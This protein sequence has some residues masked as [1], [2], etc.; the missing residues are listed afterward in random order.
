M[1]TP[2]P[3][4]SLP[5]DREIY[6][7]SLLQVKLTLAVTLAKKQIP[8][9]Q[10]IKLVPG[11]IIHFDK[12]C[13]KPLNLEV[14]GNVIAVGDAVKVGDK[15]GLKLLNVEQR[16]EKFLDVSSQMLAKAEKQNVPGASNSPM[17][18]AQAPS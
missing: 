13:D 15:F 16:Q 1:S 17:P 18:V 9:D 4:S 3:A 8:T 14:D 6:W 11:A 12:P 5:I 10:I 2:E 7:R